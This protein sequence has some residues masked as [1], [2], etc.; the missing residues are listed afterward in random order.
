MVSRREWDGAPRPPRWGES[1]VGAAG[2]PPPWVVAAWH[3]LLSGVGREEPALEV[4]GTGLCSTSG[5]ALWASTALSALAVPLSSCLGPGDSEAVPQYQDCFPE[6]CGAALLPASPLPPLCLQ[7]EPGDQL[8]LCSGS[9][10]RPQG[11]LS[12][13]L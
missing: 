4:E 3:L 13:F 2:R 6:A 9:A 10:P 8:L 12:S 1:R 7:N 11:P 5:P